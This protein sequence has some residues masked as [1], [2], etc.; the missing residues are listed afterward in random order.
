MIDNEDE[1]ADEY[2]K[3]FG[4]RVEMFDK[5]EVASEIDEADNFSN[6]Q[7]ILYA[8][9][10]CFDVAERLGLEYF[11][12]LDDDY[13][14]FEHRL[15]GAGEY[16]TDAMLRLDAVFD[17]LIDYLSATP[18]LSIALAQGGDFIG[19][20]DNTQ[21]HI[22]GRKCMNSFICCTARR[23]QFGG[24]INED[25]NTYVTLGSRGVLFLTVKHASL[26]QTTTQATKGGMTETY[27]D[28]GTYAKSFYSVMHS[29]SSVMVRMMGDK[30]RRI[31]HKVNWR[32]AVPLI[33]PES[34][35]KVR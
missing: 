23:F 4:E 26:V 27:L 12:Q 13:S 25:V 35:R 20:N 8:R 29:P 24:R 5:A 19:G 21:R 22:P 3:V 32:N 28:G 30:H 14:K 2:R 18:F 7:A 9:N 34:T 31:H 16:V 10:A 1:T 11:V 6:R 15:N 17:A 33:L